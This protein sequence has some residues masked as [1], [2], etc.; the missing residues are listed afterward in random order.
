ML[1]I[2]EPYSEIVE[3]EGMSMIGETGPEGV[4]GELIRIETTDEEYLS[5]EIEGKIV[6]TNA[7]KL[8]NL[9]LIAKLKPLGFIIVERNPRVPT[10]HFWGNFP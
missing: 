5:P 6:V 2:L 4:E 10:K 7:V 9:E 1:E 8:K 3:C